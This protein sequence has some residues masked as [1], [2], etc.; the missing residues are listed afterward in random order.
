MQGTA[1]AGSAAVNLIQP[2]K[3]KAPAITNL[4]RLGFGD[5]PLY[6]GIAVLRI[7]F[8]AVGFVGGDANIVQGILLLFQPVDL[9]GNQVRLELAS[10]PAHGHSRPAVAR[11]RLAHSNTAFY[12]PFLLL[13]NIKHQPL[14]AVGMPQGGNVD[15]AFPVEM[16]V[17]LGDM[18]LHL[19]KFHGGI[20]IE[21]A[22][23]GHFLFNHQ[24]Q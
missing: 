13:G 15:A 19:R 14:K 17:Q 11:Q 7:V 12:G 3:L 10:T 5:F 16:F 22:V 24:Q 2:A 6:Q 18:G 21:Y 4:Q 23:N 1:P 9:F 8:A 20:R